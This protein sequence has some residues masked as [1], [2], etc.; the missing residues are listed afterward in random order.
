MNST[1]NVAQY[2]IFIVTG[3]EHE[4]GCSGGDGTG[5]I[6]FVKSNN[7]R[8]VKK[9]LKSQQILHLCGELK[10]GYVLHYTETCPT[11]YSCCSGYNR[12][13]DIQFLSEKES[14]DKVK[15]SDSPL[16][17]EEGDDYYS[18]YQD[19]WTT[20]HV[21]TYDQAKENLYTL[22]KVSKILSSRY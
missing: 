6:F 22:R 2:K 1:N 13:G 4:G 14:S 16:L 21:V 9:F 17:C 11:G 15:S 12:I 10:E 18:N 3:F 5:F 7:K 19:E 8:W 20:S